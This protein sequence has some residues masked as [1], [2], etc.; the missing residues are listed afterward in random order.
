MPVANGAEFESIVSELFRKAGWRVRRH[1]VVSGDMGA[2]LVVDAGNKKYVVQVKGASEGRRDRLIPL[3]SQ[4]I[5]QAQAFSRL[6]PESAAPLSVVGARRVTA[7]LAEQ[8]KL[9]AEQHAPDVA[10]GVIDTE[11]F[12]SFV[13]PGL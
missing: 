11:G 2:D 8:L 9:F 12:H 6:F 3:L 7:S 10:V 5:L 4:A 1:P 13:G